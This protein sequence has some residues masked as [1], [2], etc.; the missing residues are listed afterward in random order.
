MPHGEADDVEVGLGEEQGKERNGV[1]ER[2]RE[3]QCCT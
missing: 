1:R 2:L 3:Q